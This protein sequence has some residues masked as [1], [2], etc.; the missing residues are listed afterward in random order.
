MGK[1]VEIRLGEIEENHKKKAPLF[2]STKVF[3]DYL[4]RLT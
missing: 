3:G 4:N 2:E 1:D